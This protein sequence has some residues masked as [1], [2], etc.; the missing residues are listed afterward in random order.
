MVS[1][2]RF[3]QRMKVDFPQPEGPIRAV[4]FWGR[5][6]IWIFARACAEP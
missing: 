3:K 2:I 4:T 6:S 5:I 1:F